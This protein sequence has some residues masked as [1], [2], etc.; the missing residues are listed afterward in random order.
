LIYLECHWQKNKFGKLQESNLPS[1][2]PSSIF[3]IDNRIAQYLKDGTL[4]FL[5]DASNFPRV[6]PTIDKIDNYF[7]QCRKD[8]NLNVAIRAAI[9]SA[10]AT[11][12]KYYE[13]TDHA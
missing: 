6:I 5:R 11:L 8:G 12:N 1:S 3:I 2:T 13:L 9:I 10:K 7:I 4:F